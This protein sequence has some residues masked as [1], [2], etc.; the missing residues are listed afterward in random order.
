MKSAA[1]IAGILQADFN[2]SSEHVH[3][4]PVAD[5]VSE[6]ADVSL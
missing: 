3:Q 2:G 6:T 1:T 4:L 5:L